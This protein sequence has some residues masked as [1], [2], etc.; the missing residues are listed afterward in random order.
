MKMKT[1]P[2]SNKIRKAREDISQIL[3]RYHL[4]LPE[5]MGVVRLEEKIDEKIWKTIRKD[6]ERIQKRLF[7]KTYPDLWKGL[8]KQ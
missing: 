2:T 5:V 8:K 7:I 4:T 3:K 1:I 6:Y